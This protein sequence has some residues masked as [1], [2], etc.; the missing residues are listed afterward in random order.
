M[1]FRNLQEKLEKY[2]FL[3]C[4]NTLGI[5]RFRLVKAGTRVVILDSVLVC[6]GL[7][8]EFFY[9]VGCIRSGGSI[10]GGCV[11]GGGG[12]SGCHEGRKNHNLKI[13]VRRIWNEGG[14]F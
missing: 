12:T 1:G 7:R 13:G 4:N 2:I 14:K 6:E 9:G 3:T 8:G 5:L 10:G 11:S